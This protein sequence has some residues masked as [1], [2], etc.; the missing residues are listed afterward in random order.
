M[1]PPKIFIIACEPSG[2][3]H[4]AHLVEAL[5]Q[6]SPEIEFFG[7][8]G[9]KMQNAGVTLLED[10]TRFSA[11]GLGDVLRQYFR[12]REVFYRALARLKAFAPDTV[13]LIDSPGFN[14][15]FAKKLKKRYRVVYYISPQIWAW[16]GRR[17]KTIKNTVHKMLVILPFEVGVYQSAG[18]PC[19]FVGHP[20]L[21]EI[22]VS[23]PREGMRREWKIDAETKAIG[24]LPGSR[25]SE[26]C[27]ILPAMMET[28]LELLKKGGCFKFFV[29][30]SSNVA[31][32]VYQEIFARYPTLNPVLTE[33]R[34]HDHLAAFD[35][36][37]IAS[38]TTTLEAAILSTPFFLLYKASWTTYVIGRRLIRVSY[39]G[40][41]NLLAKK[42]VVPE[43]I[44][45]GMKPALIAGEAMRLLN[46][47]ARY[48]AMKT[49]F[50]EIKKLLGNQGAGKRAADAILKEIALCPTAA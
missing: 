9:P 43:F 19:E 34:F 37:L 3:T 31:R 6:T 21:D 32:E 11:L 25:E 17:I 18:I 39:L 27:R 46:D 36:A 4:G 48:E 1:P 8:G 22:S 45:G 10:M 40:L 35:F 23:V 50:A 20:L 42:S 41:V 38:G 44:Q 13:I 16:G 12:Y 47:P 7:L 30:R 14:L 49:Q 29:T 15:R 33:T 28:A 5:K 2:D 24:L 26:V